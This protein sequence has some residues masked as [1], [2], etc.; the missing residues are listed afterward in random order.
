MVDEDQ[1]K[2][3]EAAVAARERRNSIEEARRRR[4]SMEEAA[5]APPQRRSSVGAPELGRRGSVEEDGMTREER[6]KVSSR[7][8]ILSLM[9]SQPP[10]VHTVGRPT[11]QR[12]LRIS[13]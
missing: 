12:S 11:L 10:D 7:C 8:V 2:R 6:I 3:D 5:A 1:R 4:N 13:G 9:D